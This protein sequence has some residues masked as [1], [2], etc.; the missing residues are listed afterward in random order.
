LHDDKGRVN[1][2]QKLLLS[3]STENKEED[4]NEEELKALDALSHHSNVIQQFVDFEKSEELN[5]IAYSNFKCP[6]LDLAEDLLRF[7]K[8]DL[9]PHYLIVVRRLLD[10][11]GWVISQALLKCK[12]L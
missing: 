6:S 7:T 11:A 8:C 5:K 1:D 3:V 9:T 2:Y 4:I 12:N 10:C